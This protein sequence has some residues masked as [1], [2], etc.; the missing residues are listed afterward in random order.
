MNM[1]KVLKGALERNGGGAELVRVPNDRR[2]TAEG[3][4]KLER[5]I[6][7]QITANEVMRSK[8]M[9]RASRLSR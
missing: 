4:R 7:A 9:Q 8:S 3:L 6:S 1:S 5:E 2:P